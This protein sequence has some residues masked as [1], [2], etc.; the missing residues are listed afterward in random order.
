MPTVFQGHKAEIAV[1]DFLRERSFKIIDQNW[2]TPRCEVDLIVQKDK[3]I[4]FVEVK[5]RVQT[6]QG[7]GLAYITSKKLHQLHFAAQIWNQQNNWHGDFRL[8][9]AGVTGLNYENIDLVEI[10]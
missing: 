5:Y 3:V 9:A 6:A 8:L 2:R 1:A 4:Y 7:D 10:D